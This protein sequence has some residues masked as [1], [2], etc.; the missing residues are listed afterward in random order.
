MDKFYKIVH[1]TFFLFN[2]ITKFVNYW[3]INFSK[4]F[5][6]NVFLLLL[7]KF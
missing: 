1:I 4:N 6:Q 7:K 2:L 5:D 3:E